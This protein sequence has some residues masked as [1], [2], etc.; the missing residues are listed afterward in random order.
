MGNRVAA[1]ATG[2]GGGEETERWVEEA[3]GGRGEHGHVSQLKALFSFFVFF[4]LSPCLL[5]IDGLV[6]IRTNKQEH[7]QKIRCNLYSTQILKLA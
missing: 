7:M 2:G 1:A 6:S 5:A 3:M 4:F